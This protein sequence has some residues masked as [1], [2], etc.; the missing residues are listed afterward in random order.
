MRSLL[1]GPLFVVVPL[2][3]IVIAV[4]IGVSIGLT[5]LWMREA[6]DN[7]YAPV[8]SAG[9]VTILIMGVAGYLSFTSPD[10]EEH[11]ESQ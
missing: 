2:L 11:S 6:F 8:V 7:A 9:L 3:A 4:A 1:R 10:P 5:N